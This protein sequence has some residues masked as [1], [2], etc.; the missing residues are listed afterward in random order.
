VHVDL[1]YSIAG[2]LVG[3]LVGMTGVGGGSLMTPILVLVFS[4]HPATAVGTDLLYASATKLVGT[5]VHGWRGT[6]D[7]KVVRRL[8]TGS[9]P[10]TLITLA[11]LSIAK[12]KAE[13]VGFV[14][15]KLLGVA[16]L[17]TGVMT[18]FRRRIVERLSGRFG[19]YDDRRIAWLTVSLGVLLGALVTLT[20]V[21]AGA[22][23]MTALLV[24]YP[25]FPVAR[26][27]GSDIAHAVPLTLVAGLGHLA[28]G[29]V[30]L[31]LLVSLLIGSIPG[32]IVGSLIATRIS[33]RALTPILAVTLAI[34]GA[35][36]VV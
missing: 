10:A 2:V 9:L 25:R 13:D 19:R 36:L 24:L 12:M 3:L 4:F 20:S 5:G 18:I 29:S 22:L 8:A 32:I 33:D 30:N 21:G 23:G 31:S 11:A 26:L 28:L 17:L 14:I 15:T 6:V 7:W 1:L 34:V 27:V 35:R 16:L